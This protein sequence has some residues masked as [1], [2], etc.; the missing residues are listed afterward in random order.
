[1]HLDFLLKCFIVHKRKSEFGK[2]LPTKNKYINIRGIYPT[3][4]KT[5]FLSARII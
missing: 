5:N 1:M 2:L 4:I 3:K